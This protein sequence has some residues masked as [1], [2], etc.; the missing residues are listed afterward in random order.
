MTKIIF[1]RNFQYSFI[2]VCCRTRRYNVAPPVLLHISNFFAL[3]MYYS[4]NA[5]VCVCAD[6]MIADRR[7][8][9]SKSST[10]RGGANRKNSTP[11]KSQKK[12]TELADRSIATGRAKRAA[13]TKARRGLSNTKKP[14]AMEIDQE[15]YRQSRNSN[16]SNRKQEQKS[17]NGRLPPNS[18]LRDNTK[19]NSNKNNNNNITVA[20]VSLGRIPNKKQMNAALQGMKEAGC[21][22]PAGHTLIMQFIPA[23]VVAAPT[24]KGKGGKQQQQQQTNKRGGRGGGGDGRG[25]GGGGRG[26]RK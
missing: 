18:S 10:G 15:N 20:P 26:G 8:D 19:K 6:D 5:C 24:G 12:K 3:E 7:K 14:T 11:T 25:R 16:A 1:Q 23:L 2:L 21:P 4:L 22:V 17:S 9:Q 13:A